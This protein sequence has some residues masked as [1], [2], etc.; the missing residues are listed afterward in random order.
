MKTAVIYYSRHHGNTKKVLD[1][2][3]QGHDLTLINAA[4]TDSAPLWEYDLI[5]FASGI[6]FSNFQKSVLQFAEK[7]LPEGKKVFFVYTCG[8][9]YQRHPEDR[10]GK[11]R[12]DSGRIRLPRLRHLRTAEAGGRHRKGT[13]QPGRPVQR[14]PFL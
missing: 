14:G 4:E 3:A 11:T 9:L 6:Y 7:H 8:W 2:I 13:P 5:G 1:A 12:G 10:R